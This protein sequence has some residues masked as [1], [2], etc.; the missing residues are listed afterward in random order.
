[1]KH[2]IKHNHWGVSVA[3]SPNGELLATG[4]SDGNARIIEVATG[5]VKQTIQHD[6]R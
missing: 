1:M 2:A 4:S 5:I 3:F 6:N